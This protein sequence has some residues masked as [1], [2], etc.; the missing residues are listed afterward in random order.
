MD[1][2]TQTITVLPDYALQILYIKSSLHRST[3]HNSCWELTW[4][5]EFSLPLLFS[6]TQLLTRR[7]QFTRSGLLQLWT[8]HG[9]LP[10]RTNW[11]WTS[12]SPI[13]PGSDT[14]K[15]HVK[16]SLSALLCDVTAEHGG[17]VTLS[18]CCTIQVFTAVA[19]CGS[20]RRIHHFVYCCIIAGTC[21][22]VTVLVWSKYA[23]IH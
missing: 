10:P 16:W 17:H 7:L 8:S 14:R 20:A 21:F 6:L 15:N 18:D 5:A 1:L 11:K 3:L 13:N 2:N 12:V 19:Q 22:E 9:C 23:T 4:T